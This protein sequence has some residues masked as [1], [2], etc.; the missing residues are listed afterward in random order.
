MQSI[1]R[2]RLID[3]NLSKDQ[4]CI[5]LLPAEEFFWLTKVYAQFAIIMSRMRKVHAPQRALIRFWVCVT[6]VRGRGSP[7]SR[8]LARTSLHLH[9]VVRLPSLVEE[10]DPGAVKPQCHQEIPTADGLDEV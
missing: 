2:F 5:R 4:L 9:D 3:L 6:A 10:L 7:S 8:D 1:V